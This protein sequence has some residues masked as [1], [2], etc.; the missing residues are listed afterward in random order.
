MKQEVM[1]FLSEKTMSRVA[2][3][4]QDRRRPAIEHEIAS[5]WWR[6]TEYYATVMNP[7]D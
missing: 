7:V 4:S 3:Q 2:G 1:P 6:S 5:A